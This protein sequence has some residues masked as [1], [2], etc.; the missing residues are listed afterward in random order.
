MKHTSIKFFTLLLCLVLNGLVGHAQ[1]A[2]VEKLSPRKAIKLADYLYSIGSYFNAIEYY[3]MV[4]EK[5]DKN[6]YAVDRI[7]SSEFNLRDYKEAEKWYKILVDLNNPEYPMANFRY[8]TAL[9]MNAKYPQ[10]KTE[11]DKIGTSFKGQ[12]ATQVK[13]QAKAQ[14]QGCE[15]AMQWMA[16]PDTVSVKH[17]DRA[18]NAP[19]TEL[20]PMPLGNDKLLYAS[21]KSDKILMVNEVKKNDAYA[22]FYTSDISNDSIFQQGKEYKDLP[23]PNGNVHVG[24]GV[25]SADKKR[26]YYTECK[27]DDKMRMRCDIYVTEQVKGK[28][29]NPV[30]C[31]F[32]DADS[33]NTQPAIGH[34]KNGE[35]VYFASNRAQSE[36]GLDLYYT[37]RDKN[38]AYSAPM[39]LGKKVNTQGDEATP[40]Y[41]IKNT[42]LYFSSN[43]WPGMGG[44]DVFKTRGGLKK[45][46]A[47]ANL[48]YPVNSSV[49]DMYYVLDEKRYSGYVVSNRPGTISVKSET[50]CDDIWRVVYPR[51]ILYAVKGNVFDEETKQ[52]VPG[53]TVQMVQGNVSH[54]SAVSKLDTLYL[55]DTEVEQDYSIVA[56]KEGYFNN[57]VS[58]HV[59][60][61]EDN[62]TMRVDVYIKKIPIGPLVIKNIYYDFDKATLRPESGPALD[63]LTTVL[64]D[65]PSITVQI[66][67]HT[68]SKGDDKYNERL[69]QGRAQSVVDYLVGKGIEKERLEAKGMGE[70]EPIAPNEV[71]GKDNP[72][73]RQLN[74]RTD[75]KITGTIP[76]KE[77][78][79]QQ[80]DTGFEDDAVDTLEEQKKEEKKEEEKP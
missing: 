66:R 11:F 2:T 4:Y 27:P 29:S 37:I 58:F 64:K 78:I 55:F 5:E 13:K 51:V 8:A 26:F 49:D 36:G 74:R 59:D 23:I 31:S 52:I 39:N 10:A 80:G 17:I 33:T 65:N 67:S 53:A 68:D 24:N 48:R 21:L 20:S 25:F 76:G 40:F 14:A 30:K 56:N 18:V 54:G 3:K 41:D 16:K 57:S 46:E 15:L 73:G 43:G 50:C 6:A 62:D 72:E 28:W 42:T 79:Y 45:W 34:S 71:N 38:G 75:F 60:R 1:D 77:V 22:T 9:K 44:Y 63:S 19:Y 7:A 12:N 70:V 32:N 69:S 61:K 35:V 47:A